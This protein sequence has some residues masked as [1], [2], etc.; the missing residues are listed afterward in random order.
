MSQSFDDYWAKLC[1]ANPSL[2]DDNTT[3]TI[4]VASFKRQVERAFN[5]G[6]KHG[7]SV[8]S[9][10]MSSFSDPFRSLFGGTP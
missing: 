9:G 8:I 2:H 4:R 1:R 5:S 3:M 6:K 7:V 10:D